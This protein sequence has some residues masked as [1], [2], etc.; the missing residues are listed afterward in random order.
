MLHR[1]AKPPALAGDLPFSRCFFISSRSPAYG[2]GTPASAWL[3]PPR[4]AQRHALASMHDRSMIA[5]ACAV[6]ES[7]SPMRR[8][9]YF[10]EHSTV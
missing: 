3:S 9:S 1:G 10:K 2:A 5:R 4:C 8:N 6:V 7:P